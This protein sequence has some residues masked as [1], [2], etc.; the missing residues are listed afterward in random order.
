MCHPLHSA[1]NQV[2]II[3]VGPGRTGLRGCRQVSGGIHGHQCCP[4][5]RSL[6]WRMGDC[7]HQLLPSV[8]A[9][10]HMVGACRGGAALL[11]ISPPRVVG[12]AHQRR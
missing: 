1:C 11:E 3:V 10:P 5:W 4:R 12:R 7:W 9:W 6:R 8:E 2:P